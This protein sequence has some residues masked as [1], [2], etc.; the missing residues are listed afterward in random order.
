MGHVQVPQLCQFLRLSQ[1]PLQLPDVTIAEVERSLLMPK[2]SSLLSLLMTCLL[3][4]P[5]QRPKTLLQHPMPYRVWNERLRCRLQNW[6][7][8]YMGSQRNFLKVFEAHGLEEQF[9]FIM[10]ETDPME[11]K[12]FHELDLVQRV[13]L[14]KALCDHKL[15]S[16]HRF[17]PPIAL[18]RGTSGYLRH[19]ILC[20]RSHGSAICAIAGARWCEEACA[21]ATDDEIL[22][23]VVPE[24][25]SGSDDN[26]DVTLAQ[27][28][29]NQIAS[30]RSLR[31]GSIKDF[32]KPA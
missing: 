27:I 20:S 5:Q 3:V 16:S 29:A 26:D 15:V 14:L 31:Q 6:Y 2:K 4:A 25:E 24:P 18:L 22:R 17:S 13:W 19:R 21:E 1:E 10:G 9:F 8:T 11:N 32:F 30:K 28:R 12:D 7:R 23:Q